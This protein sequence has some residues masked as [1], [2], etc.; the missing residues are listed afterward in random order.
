MAGWTDGRSLLGRRE[1]ESCAVC[2]QS[3][4]LLCL[5][6]LQAH[7]PAS[8][9]FLPFSLNVTCVIGICRSLVNAAVCAVSL[10][11]CV[12]ACGACMPCVLVSLLAELTSRSV[13][14]MWLLLC[15]CGVCSVLLSLLTCASLYASVLVLYSWCTVQHITATD[16]MIHLAHATEQYISED[17]SLTEAIRIQLS[18]SLT[19]ITHNLNSPTAPAGS[20]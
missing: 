20:W 4:W 12:C 19:Q 7:A 10:C 8:P 18:D 9:L 13:L 11:S 5:V 14:L 2:S 3:C 17:N 16:A 6:H 15:D 1:S